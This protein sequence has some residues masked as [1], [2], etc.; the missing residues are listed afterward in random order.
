MNQTPG[1]LQNKS[2][3]SLTITVSSRFS[4][5]NTE[6][7]LNY[8]LGGFVMLTKKDYEYLLV[9]WRPCH[10]K[11]YL[12]HSNLEASWPRRSCGPAPCRPCWWAGSSWWP[13]CRVGS[14][15]DGNIIL[16]ARHP[17]ATGAPG[18]TEDKHSQSKKMISNI[19][20]PL[21]FCRGPFV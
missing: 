19:Y 8:N 5:H 2:Q 6:E 11:Q 13:R 9:V 20:N 14:A 4:L 3:E 21:T 18:A 1:I 7:T 15:S 17:G 16:G 12:I 10:A